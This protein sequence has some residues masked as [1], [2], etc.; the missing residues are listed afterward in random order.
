MSS[1]DSSVQNLCAEREVRKCYFDLFSLFACCKVLVVVFLICIL[2]C[3]QL[4]M[5][6]FALSLWNAAG[7]VIRGRS[8]KS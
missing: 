1:Y 6:L 5:F 3:P 4:F 8:V 7:F 2:F